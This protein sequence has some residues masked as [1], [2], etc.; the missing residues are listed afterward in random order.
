MIIELNFIGTVIFGSIFLLFG[1]IIGIL[2]Y[3]I[4]KMLKSFK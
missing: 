3:K 2:I 4:I 1:A